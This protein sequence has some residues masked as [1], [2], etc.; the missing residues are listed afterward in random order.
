YF[1][2]NRIPELRAAA[3]H[4]HISDFGEVVTVSRWP[5]VETRRFGEGTALRTDHKLASGSLVSVYN[6]HMP[7]HIH[8]DLL[9]AP[10]EFIRD[11]YQLVGVRDKLT[12]Q[13]M[14]DIAGNANPIIVAGDFNTSIAM[15]SVQWL[16]NR[17]TDS[18]SAPQCEWRYGTWSLAGLL[19]WRID[20]VFTSAQLTP[21][22]YC[23]REV[24]NISDHRAVYTE[25][26]LNNRS[27]GGL[28]GS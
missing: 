28:H 16:S 26:M 7:V 13:L 21:R 6:V 23:T 4:F 24:A 3:P 25:L 27:Q 18:Y 1:P 15:N 11:L 9:S 14:E 10:G 17:F 8:F 12:A 2:T 19:S 22:Y 20:Y 5:V